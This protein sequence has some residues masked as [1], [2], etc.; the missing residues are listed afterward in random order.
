MGGRGPSTTTYPTGSARKIQR[1]GLSVREMKP[2][3]QSIYQEETGTTAKHPLKQHNGKAFARANATKHPRAGGITRT[4]EPKQ[5]WWQSIRQGQHG[6]ASA[7]MGYHAHGGAQTT[8]AAKHPWAGG[9]TRTAEPKRRLRQH[10]T[11]EL[12]RPKRR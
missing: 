6:K 10:Q 5:Q 11:S 12:G 9:I 7:G 2:W 3:W 8:T 4:V 1:K